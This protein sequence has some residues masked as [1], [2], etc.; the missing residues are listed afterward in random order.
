[1]ERCRTASPASSKEVRK[2]LSHAVLL[3]CQC[4]RAIGGV[5]VWGLGLGVLVGGWVGSACLSDCHLMRV[6]W[7]RWCGEGVWGRWGGGG[8]CGG[9]N[10]WSPR[11]SRVER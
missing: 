8:W 6:V 9:S 4:R 1:M 2:N 10:G 11:I 7:W 3:A 5:G